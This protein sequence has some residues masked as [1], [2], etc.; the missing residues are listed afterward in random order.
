MVCGNI[1]VCVCACV[2]IAA[3][4]KTTG[5][6]GYLLTYVYGKVLSYMAWLG[7]ETPSAAFFGTI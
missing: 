1:C 5:K 6:V 2:A 4:S 3:I 7:S